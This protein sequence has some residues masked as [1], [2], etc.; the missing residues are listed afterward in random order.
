MIAF[1]SLKVMYRWSRLTC[2]PTTRLTAERS[3]AWRA[4]ARTQIEYRL[5]VA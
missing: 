4:S 3:E 1:K 5:A 2:Q